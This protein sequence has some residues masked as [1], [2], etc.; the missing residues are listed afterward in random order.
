M[1][2]RLVNAWAAFVAT[3]IAAPLV[4]LAA[5]FAA[6]WWIWNETETEP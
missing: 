6:A 4:A 3:A 1:I 2:C 5:P